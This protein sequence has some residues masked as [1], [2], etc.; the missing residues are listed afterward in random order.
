MRTGLTNLP[1]YGGKASQSI[2]DPARFSFAQGGKDGIPF[3][4]DSKTY[5][6]SINILHVALK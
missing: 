2:K 3:P 6:E 1:L 5:N 4:V